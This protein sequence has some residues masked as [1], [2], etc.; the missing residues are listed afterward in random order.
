MHRCLIAGQPERGG[1]RPESDRLATAAHAVQEHAPV[2]VGHELGQRAVLAVGEVGHAEHEAL[3]VGR[4]VEVEKI[5][6]GW[7]RV[8]PRLHR[9]RILPVGGGGVDHRDQPPEVGGVLLRGLGADGPTFRVL[10]A[11][12]PVDLHQRQFT[13]LEFGHR[14][15]RGDPPDIGALERHQV[16]VAT[17]DDTAAWCAPVETTGQRRTDHIGRLVLGGHAQRHPQVRV[18]L[19][20][21]GHDPTGLLGGEQQVEAEA[22]APGGDVDHAV[23]EGG[24][25]AGQ[26][27]ELVDHD[28]QARRGVGPPMAGHLHHVLLPV[29]LQD[30]FPPGEL[31]PERHQRPLDQG[32]GEIGDH[33]HRVVEAGPR[34]AALTVEALGQVTEGRAA[35]VIDKQK[36]EAIGGM[37]GGQGGQERLEELRLAGTGGAADQAVGAVLHQVDRERAA[38]EHPHRRAE[39][40]SAAA[41]RRRLLPPLDRGRRVVEDLEAAQQVDQVH[42][43]RQ[44]RGRATVGRDVDNGGQRP[45]RRLGRV[46]RDRLDRDAAE[47]AAGALPT[48][49]DRLAA[50]FHRDCRA[51]G[52]RHPPGVGRH[53]QHRDAGLGSVFQQAR[54]TGPLDAGA[55]VDDQQNMRGVGHRGLPG[56]GPGV[57]GQAGVEQL[58]EDAQQ[59][60]AFV[61]AHGVGGPSATG[62]RPGVV[63][64][65]FDPVPCGCP[66][67]REQRPDHQ[68]GGGV[69]RRGLEHQRADDA[70]GHGGRAGDTHRRLPSAIGR[71]RHRRERGEVA[72]DPLRLQ[73]ALPVAA[74]GHLDRDLGRQRKQP[75]AERQ[76]VVVLRLA[77]P[78]PRAEVG[79][80]GQQFLVAGREPTAAGYLGVIGLFELGDPVPQHRLPLRPALGVVLTARTTG[81]EHAAVGHHRAERD[82][83]Q[84]GHAAGDG[85]EGSAHQE[86]DDGGDQRQPLAGRRFE[87][88]RQHDF[89]RLE[90]ALDAGRAVEGHGVVHHVDRFVATTQHLHQQD[91]VAD[92]QPVAGAEAEDARDL[93]VVDDDAVGGPGVGHLHDVRHPD[94]SVTS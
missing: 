85:V 76:K 34:L 58:V 48:Q 16:G 84:A 64:E 91:G 1:Q 62:K 51:A 21:G 75:E 65:P 63:G 7:Q 67:G 30:V 93:R 43:G 24:G 26:G 44:L 2:G 29:P 23:N 36:V 69:E 77:L 86:R 57:T 71:H 83:G 78:Q 25:L 52:V 60:D 82:E 55:A 3:V 90:R 39:P 68:L 89:H 6:M 70:V 10:G 80:A 50:G 59:F 28:Q 56:E 38:V 20:H 35:L 9:R 37:A 27:G 45:G 79:H 81:L 54:E 94:D 31:G 8:E 5:H 17:A 18:G 15:R 46:D 53:P 13:H 49:G 72:G 42:R 74:L 92:H 41:A 73:P 12:Q 22:P 4:P 14:R 11:G 19:D 66:L 87:R 33:P 47:L 61:A 40:G 32:R 88:R